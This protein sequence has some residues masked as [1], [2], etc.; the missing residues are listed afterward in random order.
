MSGS[1][2]MQACSHCGAVLPEGMPQSRCPRC[3]MAQVIKPTQAGGQPSA[4]PP[5]TPEELAP[6]FPQLEIIECLGRGGMGVVYKA[7][8]KSLNRLVALKLL[9]PERADDPQ[10]AARFEKEA[11]ALAALNHPHIVAVYDFG[12]VEATPSCPL[13]FIIMEFVDGVNLRQ[14]LQT[15]RLTPK[16]ALSIV[17]PVCDALQCAHDRGIV[18]RDIKPE[19]LLIDKNGTVKIAD[20]GIAK[21]YGSHLAPRDEPCAAAGSETAG[22]AA[23][24]ASDENARLISR[25]E[26]ATLG[27]PDYAAPEQASGSADHRADIYSLGVVLY[28]MLTDERPKE[29][30]VP[31]SKRV[32]VDIRI[33]EIVLRALE[34]VPELRFATA[35]EFRTQVE[36]VTTLSK[37]GTATTGIWF[38]RLAMLISVNVWAAMGSYTLLCNMTGKDSSRHWYPAIAAAVLPVLLLLNGIFMRLWKQVSPEEELRKRREQKKRLDMLLAASAPKRPGATEP[39][40]D[41][42][43][44]AVLF[45]TVFF[46]GMLCF[47]G[48]GLDSI[49]CYLL[50]IFGAFFIAMPLGWWGSLVLYGRVSSRD[51]ALRTSALRWFRTLSALSF[52]LAVAA[53]LFC[54]ISLFRLMAN[55]GQWHSTPREWLIAI[56]STTG[57]VLMFGAHVRLKHIAAQPM[58]SWTRGT[59]TFTGCLGLFTISAVVGVLVVLKSC[60]P[61]RSSPVRA[62]GTNIAENTLVEAAK[63]KLE[64]MRATVPFAVHYLGAEAARQDLLAEH[65]ELAG[66]IGSVDTATNTITL[67]P[68]GPG[69]E[70]ARRLLEALDQRPDQVLL[71]CEVR[72]IVKGATGHR[73]EKVISR[74]TLYGIPNRAVTI[75]TGIRASAGAGGSRAL[76]VNLTPSGEGGGADGATPK[77]IALSGNFTEVQESN[78]VGAPPH[79]GLDTPLG[80]VTV[81]SGGTVEFTHTTTGGR[82]LRLL[83]TPRWVNGDKFGERSTTSIQGTMNDDDL[84]KLSWHEFDQSPGKYW[85][86]L[87]DVRRFVDAA[88]LIERYLVLH[89]EIE[90]IN[91]ANLHF[92]TGQCLAMGGETE[93]AIEKL[94]LARHASE[95]LGG[96]LWND[97]VDGT[98]AFLKRDKQALLDAHIRLAG[99]DVINKPNVGVLDRLVAHFGKTY[100]DA[101]ETAGQDHKNLS[102]DCF[103]LAWELLQ[104]KDRTKEDDAR[105]ISLAHESLAH[106]RM[107]DDCTDRNLSIGY[108]Q[109]SR[110]YAV[111]GQGHNAGRYGEL[112]LQVSGKEEPFYLA[113]AHEALA[114][115]ALLNQRR[116]LFDKHLAEARSL[117]AKVA[118]AGEKKMLDDDLAGLVWKGD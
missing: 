2:S 57:T 23:A 64:H 20:F 24:H 3:L 6:H 55:D 62:D 38:N 71:R 63:Q 111:V 10:F 5:L 7:R 99:G 101:Y 109:I 51:E 67:R 58:H 104:K 41:F 79:R 14:L 74:P 11:Q 48:I 91:A 46:A 35:A 75:S 12:S 94:K 118:D 17:P 113:Y 26:M 115:A 95:I 87:A 102:A 84:K 110:V 80:T 96:L 50:L 42:A 92:H 18:H 22:T 68:K 89:P 30:L 97:Y 45:F 39:A 32:Q 15:K 116:D 105:M 72:E 16:E 54:G 66:A 86:E 36:A 107:R 44:G 28:E 81:A 40:P 100:A 49:R 4:I 83:V 37:P 117:S 85:R 13:Y 108:W 33:D 21:M 90:P 60:R 65:P 9:A 61:S 8:Q 70:K 19:N 73:E 27:T 31:P 69:F 98:A 59:S 77:R 52:G 88:R 1:S 93:S 47:E 53:M 112:C 103:N 29:N 114:R 82:T 76:A 78:I 25:S 43:V 106:W 56:S 34:K